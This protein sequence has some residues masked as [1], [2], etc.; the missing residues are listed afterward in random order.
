MLTVDLVRTRRKGEALNLVAITPR[1]RPRALELADA[2]IRRAQS[3][4]AARR[5]RGGHPVELDRYGAP[6]A[7]GTDE[8]FD[9]VG[10]AGQAGLFGS[11]GLPDHIPV[12]LPTLAS[13]L[14][15]ARDRLG[16]ALRRL[17]SVGLVRVEHGA[18]CPPDEG[19]Q[20]RGLRR[21][22]GQTSSNR[23]RTIIVS[24]VTTWSSRA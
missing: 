5:E 22:I 2:Y 12:H 10:A 23:S 14:E 21:H 24:S 20:G 13:E 1:G 4:P 6:P 11:R 3:H 8:F 7:R 19:A 15:A 18:R 9:S 16:G 17:E